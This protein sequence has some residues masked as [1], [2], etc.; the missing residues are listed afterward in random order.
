MYCVVTLQLIFI[1]ALSGF[2]PG[3]Y[4]LASLSLFP[5]F[6]Q[7]YN[8]IRLFITEKI[9]TSHDIFHDKPHNS[10]SYRI[11]TYERKITYLPAKIASHVAFIFTKPLDFDF[12]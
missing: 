6:D 1:E 7:H 2:D 5:S 3:H 9:K 10:I 12:L 8:K 4:K 11:V